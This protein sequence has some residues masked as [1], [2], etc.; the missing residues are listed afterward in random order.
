[1]WWSWWHACNQMHE[2][3]GQVPILIDVVVGGTDTISTMVEWTIAELIHHPDI[4]H[5]FRIFAIWFRKKNVCRTSLGRK[6]VDLHTAS[7]LHCFEWKMSVGVKLELS[8]KFGIVTK[9]MV[10]LVAVPTPRLP[11]L[12]LYA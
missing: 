11:N 10:P 4:M 8:D 2:H 9:K 5:K 1:M 12:E 7:F 3:V 6:D